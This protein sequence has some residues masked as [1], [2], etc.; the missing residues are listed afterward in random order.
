[1]PGI[2]VKSQ[3]PDTILDLAVKID[4]SESNELVKTIKEELPALA[5]YQRLANYIALSSIFL[6]SN[7]LGKTPLSQSDLT[8]RILGH[9]GT[10]PGLIFVY[11]HLSALIARIERNVGEKEG[12]VGKSAEDGKT[13][14][15]EKEMGDSDGRRFMFVTGPG[16]GAPAILACT[17]IEGSI[18]YFYPQYGHSEDGLERFVRAFS[19][20]GSPFPSHVNAA[21]PGAI[22]EGGELG[23]ALAVAWGSVMDKPDLIT[24]VVVGDGEAETGPTATAWHAPK[25]V[26]P[27]ESGGVIPILHCNGFKISERTIFGAMDD[28]ELTALFTGYGYQVR[29]VE[30]STYS[31]EHHLPGSSSLSGLDI[32]L[33]LCLHWAYTTILTIQRAARSGKPQIKSRWPVIILRTPKGWG[34]PQVLYGEPLENSY[35]SHQVPL[36]DVAKNQEQFAMLKAWLESYEVG[37]Y[38]D[39]SSSGTGQEGFVSN[40]VMQ[41]VPRVRE[42]R[43]SFCPET[44][45]GL[46]RTLELPTW[47]DFAVKKDEDVS[48]MATAGEYIKEAVRRNMKELRMFSPDEL[49]SNKLSG[50]LGVTGRNFQWDPETANSGG[51][52]IEMLSEHTLQG[53]A[54]GYAL[55]GR[56]AIFP[57]YEAFLPIV[58]TMIIQFAKFMKT[59]AEAA[60]RQPI[61]SV[62][63]IETSTLWRQEHNGFSHQMPGLINTLLDLPHDVARIYLPPDAN[64]MLSTVDHCLRSRNYVNL[65]VGSKNPGRNWLNAEDAK[66]HCTAGASVWEQYSTDGGVDP[67]VVLVAIGTEPTVEVIMAATILKKDMPNL[68]VRVVNVTDLMCLG[69]EGS[70]PH[71][72]NS[73]GFASLFTPSSP[74]II[75][76]H[77]Y[78]SAVRSLLH[79]RSQRTRLT[80][81]GPESRFVYLGYEEQGSTT[82]PWSMLRLN[83]VDRYSVAKEALMAVAAIAAVT[84]QVAVGGGGDRDRG[85]G[86]VLVRTHPLVAHYEGKKKEHEKYVVANG[87]DPQWV[88]LGELDA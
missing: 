35:R 12:G 67:H 84:S 33:S 58:D 85:L 52:V 81:F 64:C 54:Q 40:E 2:P 65:I 38:L 68:R 17:W 74:V 28:R 29:F 50:V 82:T 42:R 61:P 79:G 21:T 76:F 41:I 7:A 70:H 88:G 3:L 1:M 34:A 37:K 8:P 44:Y 24:A 77:G 53:F 51:R 15:T 83:G 14:E 23:Y 87:E 16:H 22:H 46:T 36:K 48:T 5:A 56:T 31:Q 19:W 20:P 45:R 55:T 78:P 43:L 80:T 66:K 11:A 6:K 9:W 30:Y 27:A 4:T 60:W 18:E 13:V 75:S 59:S 73:A 86:E 25:F 49:E 32:D 69:P 63:Y 47:Q 10:C 26:D 62:T 57:S 71:A 39:L 72:L